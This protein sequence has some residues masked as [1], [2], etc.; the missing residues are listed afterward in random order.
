MTKERF[1]R[2]ITAEQPEFVDPAQNGELEETLKVQKAQLKEKKV[3]VRELVRELEEQGRSLA[4]RYQDVQLQTQQL[5]TLPSEIAHLEET[6]A[7]LRE[8]RGPRSD[9]PALTLPLQPTLELLND[10]EEELASLDRQ[11]EAL[12]AAL[13]HKQAQVSALQDEVSILNAKKIR[14]VE[15][16]M[17]ARRG[18]EGGSG[19]VDEVEERGRWLRG[20]EQ[21]LRVMLEA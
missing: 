3:E 11:V 18:R 4:A 21:G 19:V 16:A 7:Q 17:E 15:E 6:I 14:A 20:V 5:A 9:N 12:R 8:Q 10:R 1:L 2:A 13:P